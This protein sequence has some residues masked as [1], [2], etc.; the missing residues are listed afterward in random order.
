MRRLVL[1][2]LLIAAALVTL[3]APALAHTSG[4]HSAHSCPSDH[5]TYIWY[6]GSGQAWDCASPSAPER[7]AAD[8]Q[9]ITYDGYTYYCHAAGST[10]P[11]APVDSDYDGVPDSSDACP[12]TFA[13]TANGCPAAPAPPADG[14]ADG[15]PDSS[16][17]CPTTAAQTA[18]GCPAV[19][20]PQPLTA[21]PVA[22]TCKGRG[23]LPDRHCTPG[24]TFHVSAK[25]VCKR[26]YSKRVRNVP[27]SLKDKVYANYGITEHS[28]STYEMDH[29]ISLELGGSNS[30]ENLFPEAASPKPGFHEKDKLENRLH[31]EVC[32]GK[33][34]L[35]KA[36]RM[37]ASNWVKAYN[38]EFSD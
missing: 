25:T 8:T 11:P 29:L 17:A 33:L 10:T 23:P 1:L 28:A 32:S 35:K 27:E 38:R 14:D 22:A 6:D 9:V 19:A 36:Q 30:I 16:D 3:A 15:V 18:N 24:A 21:A 5:H 31:A 26:G 13:M 20:A 4:C 2:A 12:T 7:S 34:S 37:I